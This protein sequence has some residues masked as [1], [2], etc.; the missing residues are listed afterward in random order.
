MHV[1]FLAIRSTYQYGESRMNYIQVQVYVYHINLIL[2][3]HEHILYYNRN[4]YSYY[5]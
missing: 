1:V 4:S 2:L 3:G 5:L